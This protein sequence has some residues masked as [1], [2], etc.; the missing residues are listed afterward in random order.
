MRVDRSL[1]LEKINNGNGS[2][3]P[4]PGTFILGRDGVVEWSYVNVDYR[5]R[6]EPEEIIQALK[7]LS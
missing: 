6:S 3:L 1:D 7:K 4:I 2:V 5:T